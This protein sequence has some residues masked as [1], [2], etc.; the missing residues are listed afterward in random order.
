[1]DPSISRWYQRLGCM[2]LAFHSNDGRA[3]LLVRCLQ[4][5]LNGPVSSRLEVCREH[6]D[7]AHERDQVCADRAGTRSLMESARPQ[8][9]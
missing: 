9:P 3:R 5:S 7:G 6:S 2:I 1:M 4:A 8:Q